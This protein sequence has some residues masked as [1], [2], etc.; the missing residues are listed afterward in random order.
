MT[1]D[2][3]WTHHFLFSRFS[4]LFSCSFISWTFLQK[5]VDCTQSSWNEISL[6]LIDLFN[7]FHPSNHYVNLLCILITYP[8]LLLALSVFWDLVV[9]FAS[10]YMT[11]S[12]IKLKIIYHRSPIRFILGITA[13]NTKLNRSPYNSA[14]K[15]ATG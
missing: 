7:R 14:S 12:S 1:T 4:E 10:S 8:N 6:R 2:N 5:L 9:L 11:N 3:V 15:T 13:S